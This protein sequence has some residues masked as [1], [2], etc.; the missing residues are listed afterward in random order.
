MEPVRP[1]VDRFLMDLL[2]RRTFAASDF[3]EMSTGVCRLTSGLARELCSVA[4]AIGARVGGIA[5]DVAHRL[6]G[7]KTR[8]PIT[9]RKRQ[10]ARPYGRTKAIAPQI[11]AGGGASCEWCGGPIGAG[12]VICEACRPAWRAARTAEFVP[13]GIAKLR[14]MRDAGVDPVRTPQAR[15]KAGESRRRRHAERTEW[16]GKH[17]ERPDPES[18]R[19]TI[20]PGIQNVPVRRLARVTGL[21]IHYCALV[22]RGDRVPHPMWW[23]AFASLGEP[24][25]P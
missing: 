1:I 22:R 18:F 11:G 25:R 3:Y 16:E 12:V 23:E 19:T 5:E 2:R 14:E 20:L 15:R 4:P 10:A 21:S 6:D 9:G 13:S 7:T 8:T 17:P 24:S